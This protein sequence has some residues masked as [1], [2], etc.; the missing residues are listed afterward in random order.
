MKDLKIVRW[1]A[2]ALMFMSAVFGS[3]NAQ[4]SQSVTITGAVRDPACMVMNNMSGE[5]HRACAIACAKKGV[6]LGIESNDGTYYIAVSP[7]HPTGSANELLSPYAERS[8][9]VTG[10][11]AEAKGV[12]VITPIRAHVPKPA[13]KS[14]LLCSHHSSQVARLLRATRLRSAMAQQP[15][16]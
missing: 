1:L 7:G 13:R 10:K 15:F 8:V 14:S 5:K 12:H 4:Q 11:A 3:A 6:P 9:K 16:F 2:L